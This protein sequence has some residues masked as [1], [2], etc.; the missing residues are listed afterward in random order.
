VAWTTTDVSTSFRLEYGD[1]LELA[2]FSYGAGGAG[3]DPATVDALRVALQQRIETGAFRHLH[4]CPLPPSAMEAI[5]PVVLAAQLPFSIQAHFSEIESSRRW[6]LQM[7]GQASF[8]FMNRSEAA[9]VFDANG[10]LRLQSSIERAVTGSCFVTDRR[11]VTVL[12]GDSWARFEAPP[13]DAIDPTGGGDAFA[14]GLVGC[15]MSGFD[16]ASAVN[17]GLAMANVAVSSAS[18]N[19]ILRLSQGGS[20]LPNAFG[21]G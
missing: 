5:A 2:G 11:G 9:E 7:I 6:L 10:D 1:D 14:G 15:M 12:A 3:D 19:G 17:S 21:S 8:V 13:T 18:S 20:P 4:I 16:L